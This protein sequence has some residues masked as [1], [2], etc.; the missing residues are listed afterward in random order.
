[1]LVAL[2]LNSAVSLPS[3]CP[4]GMPSVAQQHEEPVVASSKKRRLADQ[5]SRTPPR[6]HPSSHD[7][8]TAAV[9]AS[10]RAISHPE[11]LDGSPAACLVGSKTISLPVA[12]RL[13][14]EPSPTKPALQQ[15]SANSRPQAGR[16]AATTSTALLSPCHICHRRPTKKTDVDSFADCQGCRRQTCFVCIRQ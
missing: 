12:K 6:V 14:L 8:C 10:D 13:R 5:A 15:T 3:I 16:A 4:G 2:H 9:R 11:F 7:L 1:M